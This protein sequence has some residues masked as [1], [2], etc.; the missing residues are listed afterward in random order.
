M[1]SDAPYHRG[2]AVSGL[3]HRAA[4]LEHFGAR[5]GSGVGRVPRRAAARL[6]ARQAPYGG[7]RAVRRRGGDGPEGRA[8]GGGRGGSE[9]SERLSHRPA[10][11]S[12]QAVYTR[13]GGHVFAWAKA[14]AV[15]LALS[16]PR[17][18]CMPTS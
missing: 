18:A 6:H 14:E 17:I 5:P 2:D 11:G 4:W 7:R 1:S 8:D 13:L 9:G 3:V 16:R 10:V 15:V 12:L